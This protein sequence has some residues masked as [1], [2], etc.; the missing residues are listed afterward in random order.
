M[1][2]CEHVSTTIPLLHDRTDDLPG[3]SEVLLGGLA[4]TTKHLQI[5]VH[6][7]SPTV[8]DGEG[9]HRR[10][11][12]SLHDLF[13][14]VQQLATQMG[15]G[16]D[17]MGND[18]GITPHRRHSTMPDDEIGFFAHSVALIG[19]EGQRGVPLRQRRL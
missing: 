14:M 13:L 12:A 3:S 2:T 11:P 10:L 8:Q 9:A 1:L 7:L 19:D 18:G 16:I 17:E 5:T 4:I 15:E 6:R